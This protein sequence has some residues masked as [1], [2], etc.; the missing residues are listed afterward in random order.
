MTSWATPWLSAVTL[1]L[2]GRYEG[3]RKDILKTFG[4]EMQKASQNIERQKRAKEDVLKKLYNLELK[5]EKDVAKEKEKLGK[6]GFGKQVVGALGK[7]IT[8]L[9]LVGGFASTLA[10]VGPSAAIATGGIAALVAMLGKLLESMFKMNIAATRVDIGLL[11]AGVSQDFYNKKL[12]GAFQDIP[13][14]LAGPEDFAKWISTLSAAPE[15]LRDVGKDSEAFKNFLGHMGQMGVTLDESV[16]RTAKAALIWGGTFHAL[17]KEF[18]LAKKLTKDTGYSFDILYDAMQDLNPVLK[19]LTFSSDEATKSSATF[20]D[21]MMREFK[22]LGMAPEEAK[23]L[24]EALGNFVASMSG[25]KVLGL[26]ALLSGGM[27][28]NVDKFFEN[29]TGKHPTVSM[30]DIFTKSTE[31]I[32]NQMPKG[33]RTL[34]VMGMAEQGMLPALFSQPKFAVASLLNLEVPT[35]R[36][37][38]TFLLHLK[39]KIKKHWIVQKDLKH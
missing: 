15:A 29:L 35:F 10:E 24:T 3:E 23:G 12:A 14:A 36:H 13:K 37:G 39:S 9:P 32:I 26:Q 17:D 30:L 6:P 8:S 27:P 20:V 22:A 28:K 19:Q 18:I 21:T 1:S 5:Y 25:S 4:L 7:E 16:E 2:R 34:G 11:K 33:M 31:K 38:R